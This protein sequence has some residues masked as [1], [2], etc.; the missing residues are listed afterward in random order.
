MKL[1]EFKNKINEMYEK[2]GDVD[3]VF[4]FKTGGN[5]FY[6]FDKNGKNLNHS[7]TEQMPDE[8]FDYCLIEEILEIQLAYSNPEM[9]EV[10]SIVLCNYKLGDDLEEEENYDN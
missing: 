10:N 4:D 3:V 8:Q 1:E 9:T 2:Y 5:E 7:N 6:T